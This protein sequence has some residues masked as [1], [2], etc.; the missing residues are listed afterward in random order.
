MGTARCLLAAALLAA[1]AGCETLDGPG[2]FSGLNLLSTQEE[3]AL[4]KQLAGEVEKQ[5]KVL[6]DAAMQ[7]YVRGIGDRLARVSTRTDVT[8]HFTV[9]DSPDTINAFALPGGHMYFYTGL[10]K[11]CENEAELAAVMAHEMGHVAARHHGES[12]TRLYGMEWLAGIILGDN[13]RAAAEVVAGFLGTGIAM[14]YSRAAER[15]AD[16]LGAEFLFR[17]GYPP[18]AMVTFMEKLMAQ[19]AQR[20]GGRPLPIFSSHP[21]T[22]ERHML[23]QNLM[24]RYPLEM[25]RNSPVYAERY[26]EQVLSKLQ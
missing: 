12:L 5:E 10:L 7:A 25:R 14:H 1:L 4:G 15:E 3:I 6:D 17:A 24:Q 23:L 20:G 8:Y 22:Q 2:F 21:P 9:I 19:E 11:L 16:S 26:R 13:P 18:D